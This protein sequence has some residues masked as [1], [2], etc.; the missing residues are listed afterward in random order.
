M[1]KRSSLVLNSDTCHCFLEKKNVRFGDKAR[2]DLAAPYAVVTVTMTGERGS[3][4]QQKQ[5]TKERIRYNG[6]K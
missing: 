6:S 3:C 1:T 4:R 5:W 2:E